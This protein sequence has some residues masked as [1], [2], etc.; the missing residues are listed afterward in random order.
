MEDTR[1]FNGYIGE[2]GEAAAGSTAPVT[3]G[4]CLEPD[5]TVAMR[6]E[7]C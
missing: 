5:C 6:S 3:P 2:A 7:G 4:Y 1:A